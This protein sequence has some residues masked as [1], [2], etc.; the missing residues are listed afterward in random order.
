MPSWFVSGKRAEDCATERRF[1][2]ADRDGW[3][4]I[5]CARSGHCYEMV[6]GTTNGA[7]KALERVA[8]S[9]P[10]AIIVPT[11]LVAA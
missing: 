1:V 9:F 2:I 4:L 5:E 11:G 7:R 8:G 3:A 10:D 6:Y